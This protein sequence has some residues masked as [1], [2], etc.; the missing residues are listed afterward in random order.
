LHQGHV[1][2]VHR[3]GW[4]DLAE[5][6][7]RLGRQAGGFDFTGARKLTIWA[8][9]QKGGEKVTFGFGYLTKDTAKDKKYLDSDNG[10]LNVTLTADW[11][12]Y[13]INVTGKDL[14]LIKSGFFWAW[15]PMERR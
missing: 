1:Q 11:Q 15:K 12:Q 13:T 9:G 10:T 4:R 2:G 5:P 3:Q 8:R 14:K 6:R 7:Q